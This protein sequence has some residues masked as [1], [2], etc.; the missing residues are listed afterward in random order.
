M[1][2]QHRIEQLLNQ[3]RNLSEGFQ[4]M[5]L[6]LKRLEN[7]SPIPPSTPVSKISNGMTKA[8]LQNAASPRTSTHLPQSSTYSISKSEGFSRLAELDAMVQKMLSPGLGHESLRKTSSSRHTAQRQLSLSG[9]PKLP[10]LS[11]LQSGR[12]AVANG[13]TRLSGTENSSSPG[14]SNSLGL[15]PPLQMPYRSSGG[16]DGFLELANRSSVP[17]EEKVS[18]PE[19]ELQV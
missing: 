11:P 15:P 4:E 18:E 17:N 12:S 9:S 14:G 1:E 7:L 5:A 3:N 19:I 8:T 16:E 6:R 10:S 13:G 2:G